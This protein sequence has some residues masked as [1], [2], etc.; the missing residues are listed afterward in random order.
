MT[1]QPQTPQSLILMELDSLGSRRSTNLDR[2][3]TGVVGVVMLE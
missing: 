1:P 2:E 3:Y